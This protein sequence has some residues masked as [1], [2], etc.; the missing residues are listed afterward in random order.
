ML[1]T[2]GS[3]SLS[4]SE[5][6]LGGNVFG[7]TADEAESLAVLD[8]YAEQGGN[9]IDTADTYSSWVPGHEGGESEAII[10][11]WLRRRGRR[12]DVVIAT[13]VAKCPGHRGLAAKNIK[14]QCDASLRLLQTDYIDL[15]YAHEE[16][17]AVPIEESLAAFDELVRAGKVRHI[18]AS[19]F[20]TAS[21]AAA[22]A[23]SKSHGYAAFEVVQPHY[24]LLFRGEFEGAMR[25]LCAAE[26]IACVPYFGLA[27]GF[28]TGKYREGIDVESARASGVTMYQNER[29]WRTLAAMDEIAVARTTTLPAI[30]LA[31]VAQQPGVAAPIASARTLDQLAALRPMTDLVLTSAELSA[32]VAAAA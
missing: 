30:A 3:T 13:K 10:G 28:L 23:A 27:R 19:N 16:D 26:N 17:P 1:R 14:D 25:D 24:N 12:D 29:G 5:L 20:A 31:W 6:C 7:W 21:L 2:L 11:A 32:L 9:F 22:L 4:I 15:Y 8:A 18:A